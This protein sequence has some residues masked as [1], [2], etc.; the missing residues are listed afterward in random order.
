MSRSNTLGP[1]QMRQLIHLLIEL[2]VSERGHGENLVVVTEDGCIGCMRSNLRLDQ[3]LKSD[4]IRKRR[5][6]AVEFSEPREICFRRGA[7]RV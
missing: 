2:R 1:Q 7:W 4:V 6:R 5:L 3:L